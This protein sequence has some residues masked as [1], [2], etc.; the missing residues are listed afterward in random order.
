MSPW[1]LLPVAGL[2][3]LAVGL[4]A[5]QLSRVPAD[6]R[7]VVVAVAGAVALTAF[8]LTVLL[9]RA[10]PSASTPSRATNDEADDSHSSSRLL[11]LALGIAAMPL[12][13]VLP[14]LLRVSVLAVLAGVLLGSLA[15]LARL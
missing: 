6:D 11:L 8:A 2:A 4:L 10:A 12:I 7:A 5:W 15:K 14:P 9:A 3:A 13:A 1:R